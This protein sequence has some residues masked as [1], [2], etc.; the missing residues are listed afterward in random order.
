MALIGNGLASEFVDRGLLT[1]LQLSEVSQF[2][3]AFGESFRQA[4]QKLGLAREQDVLNVYSELLELRQLKSPNVQIP[5]VQD[6]QDALNRLNLETGWFYTLDL[7]LW[8]DASDP[9]ILNYAMRDPLSPQG[10][11]ALESLWEGRKQQ[12]LISNRLLDGFFAQLKAQETKTS[13]AQSLGEIEKLRELAEEAPVIEFVNSL[14]SD[15][16]EVNASDV[17]V[18]PSEEAF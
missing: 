7:I 2:Q 4:V 14:L 9:S 12:F 17:H 16:L 13:S 10:E 11:E 18:E 5:A 3:A 15:A 6:L 1:E 8:F